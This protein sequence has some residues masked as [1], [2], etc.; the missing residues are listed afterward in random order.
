M[1][2]KFLRLNGHSVKLFNCCCFCSLDGLDNKAYEAF[3]TSRDLKAVVEMVLKSRDSDD[4]IKVKANLMTPVQPMLVSGKY[5]IIFCC[6]L[7]VWRRV[8][9]DVVPICITWN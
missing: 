2:F 1:L 8:C 6:D 7:W 9:K 5:G 4:K 3:K